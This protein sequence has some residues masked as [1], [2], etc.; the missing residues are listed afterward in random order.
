MKQEEEEEEERNICIKK[1]CLSV[2]LI[3][4]VSWYFEYRRPSLRLRFAVTTA[5]GLSTVGAKLFRWRSSR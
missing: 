3:W 4:V 1:V 2:V 5:V